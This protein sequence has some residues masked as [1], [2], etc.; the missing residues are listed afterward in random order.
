MI[1]GVA[2]NAAPCVTLLKRDAKSAKDGVEALGKIL[3]RPLRERSRI[4][5]D[6]FLLKHN[7]EL[8]IQVKI[9]LFAIK[10][11]I[12]HNNRSRTCHFVPERVTVINC[13]CIGLDKDQD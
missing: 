5:A 3:D 9:D 1:I 11:V 6:I 8:Q 12:Y 10:S 13:K 4:V 7:I 2:I